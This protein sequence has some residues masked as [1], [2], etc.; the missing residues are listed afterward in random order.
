[1]KL[2]GIDPIAGALDRD[3]I[4][5][6]CLHDVR[7][8]LLD[9][10]RQNTTT[11]VLAKYFLAAMGNPNARRILMIN[12]RQQWE[13]M[14]DSLFHGLRT[15]LGSGFVDYE[16]RLF[17]YKGLREEAL[18]SGFREYGRGF[19]YAYALSDDPNIERDPETIRMQIKSRYFDIII[20]GQLFQPRNTNVK[21]DFLTSTNL[22]EQLMWADI[23][24]YY[25]KNEIALLDGLDYH[26]V[27]DCCIFQSRISV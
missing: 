19:S 13:Y 21:L 16:K 24:K 20:I 10:C 7:R 6:P 23:S 22:N 27:K 8:V 2:P 15:L 26:K 17:L 3:K 4:N 1:M 12:A 14:T 9:Y 25:S 11:V 5:M 18:A